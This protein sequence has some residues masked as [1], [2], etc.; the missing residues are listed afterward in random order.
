MTGESAYDQ[1]QQCRHSLCNAHILRELNYVIETSKPSWA[2]EMKQLLLDIKAAVSVASEAGK[3]RLA[4][5]Q[6]EEFLGQYGRIV[7]EAGKL[8]EPLQRKKRGAKTRRAKESPIKA[9]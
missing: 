7:T 6:I 1:Y 3:T 2:H 8:Y 9:A 5:R 4:V